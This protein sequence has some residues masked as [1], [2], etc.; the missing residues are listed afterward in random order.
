MILDPSEHGISEAE[1]SMNHEKIFGHLIE[2]VII[3][4][5]LLKLQDFNRSFILFCAN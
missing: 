5:Y 2:V 1:R 4:Y 3:L